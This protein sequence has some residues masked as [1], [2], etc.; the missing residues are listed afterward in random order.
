M[1]TEDSS[2]L[3]GLPADFE[4][5]DEAMPTPVESD[6]AIPVIPESQEP[7]TEDTAPELPGLPELESKPE[8]SGDLPELPGLPT[9]SSELPPMP[10]EDGALPPLPGLPPLSDSEAG[11]TDDLPPL[12]P[13][14]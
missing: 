5:T 12:P 7:S 1:P 14:P 13:L 9:E 11:A 4:T 6:L 3:P 2:E 8:G 10:A